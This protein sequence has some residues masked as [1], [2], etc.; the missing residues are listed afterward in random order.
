[1]PAEVL[2]SAIGAE[3]AL[4]IVAALES[5]IGAEPTELAVVTFREAAAAT[6]MRSAAVAED[7]ADRVLAATAAAAPP[8]SDLAGEEALVEAGADAADNGGTERK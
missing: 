2:E 8:V 7:I 1:V 3:P 4:V 5:A 6:A